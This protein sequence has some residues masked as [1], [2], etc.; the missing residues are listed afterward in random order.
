MVTDVPQCDGVLDELEGQLPVGSELQDIDDELVEL[1]LV[2]R[3]R[4]G[5]VLDTCLDCGSYRPHTAQ[6]IDRILRQLGRIKAALSGE[7]PAMI[8]HDYTL[9][10]IADKFRNIKTCT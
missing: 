3:L 10:V 6:S 7:V 5:C 4:E 8:V 2:P 9:Q 1:V